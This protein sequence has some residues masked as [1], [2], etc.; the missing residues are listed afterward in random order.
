VTRRSS[1][2]SRYVA[3]H[4][5]VPLAVHGSLASA[6]PTR[7]GRARQ[8]WPGL[9]GMRAIAVAAVVVYHMAPGRFPGGFFGVDVFFVI[10]GYLITSMLTKEWATRGD[11]SLRGFWLRR[12]RRLY[13]A[14]VTLVVVMVL[15]AAV[16]APSALVSTRTTVPAAL[17]Y[18]TNWWFIFHK[19]PYFQAI[20]RPPLFI[21]FWSLAI[22]EQYYLIWPPVLLVLLLWWRR[23]ARIAVVAVAGAVASSVLMAVMFHAGASTDRIYYGSD[24]HCQGL[25]LGSALGLVAPPSRLSAHV[26]L[27]ARRCL[28]GAG[29]LGLATIVVMMALVGQA[30]AF[31]WRGGLALVVVLAGVAAVVAAHPASRMS[32]LL[33]VPPLRWLGTRSYSVYLWHWPILDLTRAHIDVS[34]GG[35]PLVALQLGLIAVAA[36]GS[37]RLVEQP[38]RTGR[39]QARLRDFLV[40]SAHRRQLSLAAV[41]TV[42]AL[43]ILA[44]V[45]AS[46]PPPPPEL[47][48]NATSAA[49]VHISGL[50]PTTVGPAKPSARSRPRAAGSTVTTHPPTTTATTTTTTVP[51]PV[52]AG[53]PPLLRA[54]AGG[55]VLAVGDSVMVGA[56]RDLEAAFGPSIT[57]DAAVGRQVGQ[58]IER[59]EEYRA[60]GRLNGLRA[61]IVGL[62]TNGPFEPFQMQELL[63]ITAS[64][65]LIVLVNVRVPLSWQSESDTTIAAAAGN[66]RVEVVDWY[67]ASATPGILYP[68]AIHPNDIGQVIY[69]NLLVRAIEA[70][71]KVA[72]VTT[73]T[74]APST[75]TST[76]VTTTTIPSGRLRGSS[77]GLPEGSR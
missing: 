5:R 3:R 63:S 53:A 32:R 42:L 68:D 10:S 20:G 31:T 38:W 60:A 25:L 18:L 67:R 28:D 40:R 44:L 13:P 36:E 74:A 41:G 51:P 69:T 57:V 77:P 9:D 33:S 2:G 71:Q 21:H 62:G 73:T 23:P 56:S 7:P 65:P 43:V 52:V 58:G 35:A 19:V 66:P 15:V 54:P 12:V 70:R 30:S 47:R 37:Y 24:T 17:V 76:V 39:A 75:T 1:D 14:L 48:I 46:T 34:F 6:R 16:V 22:E 11:V 59:L 29:A 8:Y 61:L 27:K 50:G 55:P 72:A 4:A 26:S 45:S 49:R 64:V